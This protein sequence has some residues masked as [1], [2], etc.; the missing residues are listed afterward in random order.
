MMQSNHPPVLLSTIFAGV[1]LTFSPTQIPDIPITGI[2]IDS[3]KVE[4]GS[5]F[6]AR[7][8]SSVDG[9][10]FIR[11]AIERGANA[12]VGEQELTGLP[13]AYIRVENSVEVVTWLAAAF[14]GT[15]ETHSRRRDWDRWQDHHLQPALRDPARCRFQGRV[16][17]NGQ[18]RHRR[19]SARHRLPR[20]NA[21]RT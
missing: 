11:A 9:H 15:P 14:H 20:Y 2:A 16:D 7:Q 21:G 4:P 1:P 19:G 12:V 5:L 8:G 10:N 17:I 18:C 13:V 3:R 6:V